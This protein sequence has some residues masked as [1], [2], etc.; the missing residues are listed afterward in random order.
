VIIKISDEANY[1]DIVTSLSKDEQDSRYYN[2]MIRP[3]KLVYNCLIRAT[4]SD[5]VNPSH[6][7]AEQLMDNNLKSFKWS[8]EKYFK[9][10]K[11]Q[12]RKFLKKAHKAGLFDV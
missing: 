4:V 7:P 12:R 10:S 3:Q 9:I 5:A 11:H 6:Y 1:L 8:S 2:V